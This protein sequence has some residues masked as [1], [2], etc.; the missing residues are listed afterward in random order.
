[1]QEIYKESEAQTN[2]RNKINTLNLERIKT[3]LARADYEKITQAAPSKSL[4]GFQNDL[5][6]FKASGDSQKELRFVLTYGFGFITMMFLGFFSG[7]VLGYYGLNLS[8]EHS[9]ILSVII[10]T[11]TIFVEAILMIYRIHKMDQQR[12]ASNKKSN[13]DMS[14]L[15]EME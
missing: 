9:L 2:I 7:Y 4:F 8:T 5:Q 6:A 14:M 10:G 11:I 1:M 3:K 15:N 12:E 13:H